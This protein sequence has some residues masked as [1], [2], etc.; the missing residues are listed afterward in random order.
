MRTLQHLV[1]HNCLL[2]RGLILISI[3]SM[4]T[5][6]GEQVRESN[7]QKNE[8]TIET[9]SQQRISFVYHGEFI[10]RD[11][12][13]VI[14]ATEEEINAFW[15]SY[16]TRG[17]A[18]QAEERSERDAFLRDQN[19]E[20]IELPFEKGTNLEIGDPP[21]EST[22]TPTPPAAPKV[23][24]NASIYVQDCDKKKV[25]IPPPWGDPAWSKQ[26]TLPAK[27]VAASRPSYRTEIWTYENSNGICIALPRIDVSPPPPDEIM[28]M[29]IICQ[30][31][32]T[33]YACFWDNID[34]NAIGTPPPKL[35]GAALIG[36]GP[37]DLQ[38]GN[39]LQ[40]NCTNCHRGDNVFLVYPGTD[41]ELGG[42]AGGNAPPYKPISS[43][44]AWRNPARTIKPL[45]DCTACHELPA[46]TLEYCRTVLKKSLAPTP[47][48]QTAP[49]PTMPPP[50]D[51]WDDKDYK[52]DV[53]KLQQACF[54]FDP[55]RNDPDKS[56]R[57]ARLD[58]GLGIAPPP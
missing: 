18:R 36:K 19:E 38:D 32:L 47:A 17:L 57:D 50:P 14:D 3:V 2:Q 9:D 24:A 28:L 20:P 26:T 22:P 48:G 27:F 35:T 55:N 6:C 40:E 49:P 29:G 43:Q 31:K 51:K 56:K 5:A 39:S 53:I 34:K 42:D 13:V 12:S 7:T 46:L 44:P 54:M 16:K 41:L 4:I 21:T 33:E 11:N 15:V 58:F 1:S 23:P 8:P 10:D 45:A 37:S 25:P 52:A 30:S